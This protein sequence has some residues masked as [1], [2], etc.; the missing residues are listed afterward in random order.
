M[1]V[2]ALTA[3]N[4]GDGQSK[5][6]PAVT[7]STQIQGQIFK[8]PVAYATVQAFDGAGNYLGQTVT[9][10][11]GFY[12]L[13]LD[14]SYQGVI[15]IAAAGG[16]YIDEATGEF[17]PLTE[18]LN[19]VTVLS[20][21]E[22]VMN[23]TL[24]TE[25]AAR[26]VSL[27][28][29]A[30]KVVWAN[31]HIAE[32]MA[33]DLDIVGE[34]PVDLLDATH[35][36]KSGANV[37]YGLVI[38][39]MTKIAQAEGIGLGKL[40]NN[41]RL[42]FADNGK[43]DD[44]QLLNRLNVGINDFLDS[45]LNR[46]GLDR[47]KTSKDKVFYRNTPPVIERLARSSL[48]EGQEHQIA[49]E[50]TDNKGSL[51]YQWQQIKGPEVQIQ[52]A[53][54]AAI[55]FK[56]P[57]PVTTTVLMFKLT[58]T[59]AEGLAAE[60]YY[61]FDLI[62][63]P[64]ISGVAFKGPLAGAT[65]KVQQLDGTVIGE[66]ITAS[67]GSYRIKNHDFY[68]GVVI[69]EVT[70]GTYVSEATGQ[71][72]TLVQPLQAAT[73]TAAKNT[74]LNITPLTE[75]AVRRAKMLGTMLTKDNVMQANQD[76]AHVF[77]LRG[78][79]VVY[80]PTNLLDASG[81]LRRGDTTEHALAIAAMMVAINTHSQSL[82]DWLEQASRDLSDNG[83]FN[84]ADLLKALHQGLIDFIR[85]SL[86]VLG[87]TPEDT[88]LDE[89]LSGRIPPEIVSVTGKDDLE[90]QMASA[91][92]NVKDTAGVSYS[93][94]QVD[95]PYVRL[96]NRL[97]PQ[98]S[99]RLPDIA[100]NLPQ[101]ITLAVTVSRNDLHSSARITL[102]AQPYPAVE[103]DK[104]T[105]SQLRRCVE[106]RSP[107]VQDTG[108]LYRL[109]CGPDYAGISQFDGLAQFVNLGHIGVLAH[110]Q[111]TDVSPLVPL[112]T[113][114]SLA[115]QQT[116]LTDLTVL[117][118]LA[119]LT[120]LALTHSPW[121][122]DFSALPQLTQL[123]GINLYDTGLSDGHIFLQMNA[124]QK[125]AMGKTQVTDFSFI[126]EK[127]NLISLGLADSGLTQLEPIGLAHQAGL[128]S[129]DISGNPLT[130]ISILSGLTKLQW[131]DLSD[132]NVSV[133][134]TLTG[135]EALR[136]VHMNHTNVTDLSVFRA[137]PKVVKISLQGFKGK[138]IS[139]L[140]DLKKEEPFSSLSQVDLTGAV[141]VPCSQMTA[142]EQQSVK[143]FVDVKP[144]ETCT[145]N[146]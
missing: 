135:L 123:I 109:E 50:I 91:I 88:S 33:L 21:P 6:Q 143:I 86:N 25:L 39:G 24:L 51:R 80:A 133:L 87:V 120:E 140:I 13:S 114:K 58:A 129:L 27:G 144:G 70:G 57:A 110:N 17:T 112:D 77:G 22:A 15:R 36:G 106:E 8:G 75:L 127:P 81:I 74:K 44:P 56:T 124:L 134:P 2:I 79:L 113:L 55:S 16:N 73:Y 117:K 65:V 42:D 52:G 49:P 69:A 82:T 11:K 107:K 105:D 26:E 142:L 108:D 45:P 59:D 94:S 128:K 66:A 28:M 35:L 20:E 72:V 47:G 23:V 30:E 41:F 125:I 60:Q 9:D 126:Q 14:S 64:V 122:T 34:A 119:N 116:V 96:Y 97:S 19:A 7:A 103:F 3:C 100:D 48:R 95:G 98:V 104:I 53:E 83:R 89:Q 29:S 92:V 54:T 40:V 115:L 131:V 146:E 84:D 63:A 145:A 78:N 18:I 1:S 138:D 10:E 12:Q 137:L 32:S 71:T 37:D 136:I 31:R 121:L 132:T 5:K 4:G 61:I 101:S 99:F 62:P 141:Q 139:P 130:D 111:I 38:A 118:D 93:W 67:D 102:Q 43:L 68:E 85:S 46:V 90:R 76:I